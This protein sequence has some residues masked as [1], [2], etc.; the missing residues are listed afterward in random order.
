MTTPMSERILVTKAGGPEQL[1]LVSMP[2]RAPGTGELR[3]RIEAAGVAFADVMVREGRYP[4][5]TLPVTPGYD[6][7]GLVD[8]VGAGVDSSWIGQRIGALTVTGGYARHAYIPQA[9]AAQ[10]PESISSETAVAL[11]LN[12]VTA[13]QMLTRNT[14]TREGDVVLVHGGGGGVGT[15]L[16]ELCCLRGIRALATAS[17]G[18][19][20]LVTRLGGM[21]IDYVSEDFVVRAREL[22]GGAGV[23]AVF[24]HMGGIHL[25]RSWEALRPTGTLISYG[26]LSAFKNGRSSLISG[27]GLILGQPRITPLQMLSENKTMVG[28]DIAGRRLAR[29]DWFAADLKE[30]C[31][32][33]KKGVLDPVIDKIL[34]LRNAMEAHQRIGSGGA[35]GKIILDCR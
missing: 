8:A 35:H 27:I 17:A 22:T 25:R 12:Y 34:P 21:P 1:K 11:I 16:L 4:G 24:D 23:D 32:L 6:L 20:D 15:A 33:T 19:H 10:I 2:L 14:Q 29:P 9:W 3:V 7:V 28:F 31:R 26:A 18:K 30:L 5:A 13:W